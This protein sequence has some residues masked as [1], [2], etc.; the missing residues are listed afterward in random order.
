[1]GSSSRQLVMNKQKEYHFVMNDQI[2]LWRNPANYEQSFIDLLL[3]FTRP[4]SIEEK[5]Q[6]IAHFINGFQRLNLTQTY[7]ICKVDFSAPD[8][9]ELTVQTIALDH[10]RAL[11]QLV[12][13]FRKKFPIMPPQPLFDFK[14]Q[15]FLAPLEVSTDTDD[16]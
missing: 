1:M 12:I 7:S 3:K 11:L 15:Q 5:Y 16:Q 9:L 13:E 2:K 10:E 4:L 6:A 14:L 8:Y